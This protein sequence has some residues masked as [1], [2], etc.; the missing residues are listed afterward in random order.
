MAA[1]I[2]P[3]VSTPRPEKGTFM[4]QHK[5]PRLPI[6]TL[7]HTTDLFLKFIRPLLSDDDYKEAEDTVERFRTDPS[8]G[9]KL[10]ELLKKFDK[11]TN[12]GS[13]IA[14]YQNI[15]GYLKVSRR[16]VINSNPFFLLLLQSGQYLFHNEGS[17]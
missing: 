2:P 15:E 5:L 10:Q 13:Y 12:A 14:D 3:R 1:Y 7:E 17:L 4:N 9:P 6:P 16:V 11:T 8:Q